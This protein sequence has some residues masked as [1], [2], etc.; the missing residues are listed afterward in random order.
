M[1][2][3]LPIDLNKKYVLAVRSFTALGRDGNSALLD[4]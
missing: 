3:D 1:S 2:D 4:P